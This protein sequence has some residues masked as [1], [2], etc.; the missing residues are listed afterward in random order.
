MATITWGLLASARPS[1]TDEVALLTAGA[2]EEYRG[3][4]RVCNQDSSTRTYRLA[5]CAAT[6]AA[7]GDEWIA[8]DREIDANTTEEWSITLGNNEEIR[9]KPSV[10][11]KISF[12][13]E[14]EKKVG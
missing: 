7:S 6:G 3:Y 4:V 9:I 14:G 1:S 8:Y 5:H 11:D 12:V 2:D 13:Y 10:I